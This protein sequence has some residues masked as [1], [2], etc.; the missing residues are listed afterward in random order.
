M[1]NN[2]SY[3]SAIAKEFERVWQTLVLERTSETVIAA[4]D[5]AMRGAINSLSERQR[6]LLENSEMLGRQVETLKTLDEKVGKIIAADE[7]QSH[8]FATISAEIEALK[9]QL[10]HATASVS[11]IAEA[12]TK[13]SSLMDT[14]SSAEFF[15][16]SQILAMKI[17]EIIKN[18][19]ENQSEEREIVKQIELE[20]RNFRAPEDSQTLDAF[21]GLNFKMNWILFIISF[22]VIFYLIYSAYN[23]YRVGDMEA[24]TRDRQRTLQTNHIISNVDKTGRGA[25]ADQENPDTLQPDAVSITKGWNKLTTISKSNFSNTCGSKV[26]PSFEEYWSAA[27]D[28]YRYRS[29]FIKLF[30]LDDL[31]SNLM[32]D[33]AKVVSINDFVS[34][35][36]R[37]PQPLQ[38]VQAFCISKTGYKV[39]GQDL[40]PYDLRL[41]AE[42]YVSKME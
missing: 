28:N 17:E 32:L 35:F 27:A 20:S 19:R 3:D 9:A 29:Y 40:K 11:K 33:C 15:L 18:G 31:P 24:L 21:Y 1:P 14:V 36:R 41:L 38:K 5:N 37:S 25:G 30:G 2:S 16:K 6:H 22:F 23:Y 4:A 8:G 42:S 10:S 13:I 12:E 26:C 34:Y 39:S 7:L